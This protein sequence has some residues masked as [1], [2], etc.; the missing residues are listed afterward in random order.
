[1]RTTRHKQLPIYLRVTIDKKRFEVTTHRH[2][3]ASQWSPASGRVKGK[4]DSAIETNMGLDMIIKKVY[5]YREQLYKENRNFTVNSLREKWF[6]QD[7]NKRTILGLFRSR[8]M[9]FEKLVE[10]GIYQ[11][12][13]LI[14]YQT[15]ERHVLDYLQGQNAGRDILLVD[16]RTAF[17]SN[18]E[19]YLQAEKGLSINSCGKMLKNLKKVIRDCVDKDW[20]DRD[21]FY[22]FKVRHVDPKIPHLSA[23]ELKALEEKEISIE[24]LAVVRDLFVF[25]CYTGF[26]YVDVANLTADNLKIGDDGKKWL[27][28]PRQKTGI[29]EIVPVFPPAL[30]ILN[31][32]THHPKLK[33]KKLLPVPTNQKV[34]AYLKELADICG[35]ETKITFHVARH[36]FASTVTLDNGIPIDSVSKMLGHRSIKTTQ[37]YAKVSSLKIE[38]D[39]QLLFQKLLKR[40]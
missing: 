12:S 25:S 31:K 30:R 27:I 17:A 21:P 22:H 39:T 34:N 16:L 26:A 3:E 24:R 10:N 7:R 11:K 19:Y 15:T 8:I 29:P 38:D 13:T 28:K 5:D 37:I 18:F 2:V 36:T 33:N 1:S 6:G 32:Y 23:S 35:V 9:D 20:L 14:K 40:V 4:S